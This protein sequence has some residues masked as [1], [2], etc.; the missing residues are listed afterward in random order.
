M[1]IEASVIVIWYFMGSV[2]TEMYIMRW[3][4]LGQKSV[5]RLQNDNWEIVHNNSNKIPFWHW[6]SFNNTW[7]GLTGRQG[8]LESNVQSK[9]PSSGPS[10]KY[11]K[12]LKDGCQ[13]P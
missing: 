3:S 7:S 5:Y 12:N 11:F 8:S 9:I 2:E 13:F 10:I 6:T 1:T 4:K